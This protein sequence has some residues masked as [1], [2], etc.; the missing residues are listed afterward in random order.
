M[1]TNKQIFNDIIDFIQTKESE[2]KVTTK[3]DL[4]CYSFKVDKVDIK[5]AGQICRDNKFKDCG[6]KIYREYYPEEYYRYNY[7]LL[8]KINDINPKVITEYLTI[9]YNIVKDSLSISTFIV[10]Y[11][12]SHTKKRY[13]P[14]N[15]NKPV[16][17]YSKHLYTFNRDS[18]IKGKL[19]IRHW[20][21]RNIHNH[22]KY[23]SDIINIIVGF[24]PLINCTI[25]NYKGCVSTFQAVLRR[26]KLPVYK[27]LELL[28]EREI[29]LLLSLV[30]CE[31]PATDYYFIETITAQ[32]L[33][34]LNPLLLPAHNSTP[35]K[36][37]GIPTIPDLK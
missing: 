15:Q 35:E 30:F 6:K 11:N 25:R 33:K 36:E 4:I 14:V 16:L 17:C 9:K 23:Y 8:E 13:Y 5:P 19:R 22:C 32:H 31:N 27:P 21:P 34:Y 10:G 12:Y 29:R 37:L 28:Q 26:E 18:T 2:Y 7:T 3:P 24:S 1:R 20:K